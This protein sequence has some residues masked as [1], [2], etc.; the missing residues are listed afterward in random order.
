MVSASSN[1]ICIGESVTFTASVVNEGDNPVYSWAINGVTT[2]AQSNTFTGNNL[3]DGDV[4]SCF[5]T[6]HNLCKS[7]TTI[8]SN[9]VTIYVKQIVKPTVTIQADKDAVCSN[10]FITFK[11]TVSES[12]NPTYRWMLNGNA[13]GDNLAVYTTNTLRNGDKVECLLL[14]ANTACASGSILSNAITETIYSIPSLSITGDAIIAKGGNTQLYA[15]A[16]G[17]PV[18][19]QWSP[20]NSLSNASIPDPIANPSSSTTYLLKVVSPQGYEAEKQITVTVFYGI[21]IPNAFSPNNDGTNDQFKILYGNDIS[22]VRFRIYSRW[23]QL[24]FEDEG[25]H[26]CWNGEYKGMQQLIGTYV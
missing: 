13:T 7:D 18:S 9:P 12:Q 23:G 15:S 14:T 11:A 3:A 6:R 24:I 20:A 2:G 25:L 17:Q 4:V 22:H 8:Q 21:S 26:N 16:G 1:T 19:Y 10:T 5:L